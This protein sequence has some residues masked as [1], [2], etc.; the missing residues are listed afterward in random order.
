M[1]RTLLTTMEDVYFGGFYNA[2]TA[3]KEDLLDCGYDDAE[4]TED[5]IRRHIY[6]IIEDESENFWSAIRRAEDPYYWLVIA[7]IGTWQG[8]RD[9]GKVFNGLT[10]AL[11]ACVDDVDDYTIA[12]DHRGNVVIHAYH[13]DG[14]NHFQLYRL[15]ERGADWYVNKGD[16]NGY[17]WQ[18]ICERLDHPSYRRN[19]RLGTLLNM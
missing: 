6:S 10:E 13:H 19:A 3:A 9:G 11:M 7:D 15:S 5:L 12:E 1:F 2:E 14:T 18:E 8:R 17:S 16:R 4:I